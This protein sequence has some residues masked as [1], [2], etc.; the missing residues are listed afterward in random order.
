METIDSEVQALVEMYRRRL[1][2]EATSQEQSPPPSTQEQKQLKNHAGNIVAGS[3]QPVQVQ[4]TDQASKIVRHKSML[5]VKI[6]DAPADSLLVDHVDCL[7][8][9]C[10][11]TVGAWTDSSIIV[12]VVGPIPRPRT[13]HTS[14]L[15]ADDDD[16]S[17]ITWDGDSIDDF[18]L[19][20][21]EDSMA[22]SLYANSIVAE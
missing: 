22:Y 9:L 6:Q 10:C 2:M 4:P 15:N 18:D 12:S 3:W 19:C 8:D 16:H 14:R 13:E 1:R 21:M 17:S 20:S 11:A 5:A 7:V